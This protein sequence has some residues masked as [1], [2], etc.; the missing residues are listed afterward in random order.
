LGEWRALCEGG[1]IGP[2]PQGLPNL[3]ESQRP[4]PDRVA[5]NE[6]RPEDN[7]HQAPTMLQ[8]VAANELS[9]E[10]N[11]RSLPLPVN[12]ITTEPQGLLPSPWQS[13]TLARPNQSYPSSES[14][15]QDHLSS[16]RSPLD[17]SPP[18]PFAGNNN[19][20]I[21]SLSAFPSP[22]THFPLSPPRQ[23]L[24]QSQS[25][26]S[27]SSYLKPRLTESP[28]PGEDDDSLQISSSSHKAQRG[29]PGALSPVT[30]VQ[31]GFQEK[32][33]VT[34]V[35]DATAGP[36]GDT[37]KRPIP[38]ETQAPSY[39]PTEPSAPS[40]DVDP[41]TAVHARGDY[42]AGTD[43]YE[44]GGNLGY[45]PKAR[46]MD[47]V[48]STERSDTLGSNGSMVA[49]MRHR[50]SIPARYFIENFVCCL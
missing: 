38:G 34:E 49:A 35:S 50:Y 22:P 37:A 39:S 30:F 33:P 7:E 31:E 47:N 25:S 17:R 1:W 4:Q 23:Q 6:R 44:F 45:K 46:T 9:H 24:S 13:P 19:D 5:E 41:R 21:R 27:S 42:V 12:N 36:L 10:T 40:V 15:V 11:E 16:A 29:S 3:D 32:R 18:R 20:S 43:Q 26:Q 28:L 2:I 48:R 8:S 14:V